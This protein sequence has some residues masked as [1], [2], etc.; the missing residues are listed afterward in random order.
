MAMT[1][2]KAQE[3]TER[4]M[5]MK[6]KLRNGCKD[7]LSS[8]HWQKVLSMRAVFDE[9]TNNY[10]INNLVWLT[11]Q[12]PDASYLA[13]YSKWNSLKRQVRKGEKALSVFAPIKGYYTKV[14]IDE[15]TGEEKKVPIQY[16]KGFLVKNSVF[17]ISQT[18]G[19]P[20]PRICNNLIGNTD[21]YQYF[22]ERMQKVCPVPIEFRD[23]NTGANGYFSRAEM[24]G[25]VVIK[26]NLSQVHTVKTLVHE[27]THAILHGENGSCK[28][29]T[30][31]EKE[32]QAESVAYIVCKHYGIDTS[33]Y[34]FPYVATWG[35]KDQ[36]ELDNYFH[37][38]DETAMNIIDAIDGKEN[39]KV[40]KN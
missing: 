19:E 20:L 18:D 15:D 23:I 29:C 33:E 16:T 25:I 5:A 7:F 30:R 32:V 21:K 12:K 17:D 4:A 14:V 2:E 28:D 39:I 31:E 3:C 10:S 11:L 40:T 1:K 36:K 22:V 6:E 8:E 35:S 37:V 34:S 24:G 9:N 38:I 27:T 13:P 26:N